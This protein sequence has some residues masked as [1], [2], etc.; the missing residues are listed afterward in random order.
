[1]ASSCAARPGPTA[2][3]AGT[4]LIAMALG[5][6]RPPTVGPVR[7]VRGDGPGARTMQ[8]AAHPLGTPPPAELL[9]PAD[10]VH[11]PAP[12]GPPGAPTVLIRVGESPAGHEEQLLVLEADGRLRTLGPARPRLRAP[13]WAADGG[14]VVVEAA[15]SGFSDLAVIDLATGG[16]RPLT[17]LPGGAF[18]PHISAQGLVAFVGSTNGELDLFAVPLSGGPT[19]PLL[20]APGE[21]LN[22]TWSPAGS[23]LAWISGR[24]GVLG[25]SVLQLAD[26]SVRAVY[27]PRQAE[28]E[29]IPDQG[30]AWSPD[31]RRIALPL[32]HQERSCIGIFDAET[33]QQIRGPAAG[34]CPPGR[35]EGV[36]WSPD[37][38]MV[39][40]ARTVNGDSDLIAVAADGQAEWLVLGGPSTDWL[41]RWD[42]G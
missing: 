30:L 31:G 13:A 28:T 5:C 16:H 26:L 17:D 3:V 42:G 15:L 7:F 2:R 25:L 18:T 19:R 12:S 14:H 4:A 41:P 9:G 37:G 40:T 21:D 38:S 35:E 29:A 8:L 32:R 6:G 23:H 33:G 20:R 24:G 39:L 10:A 1:M 11:F 34:G 36:A 22:P 27:V